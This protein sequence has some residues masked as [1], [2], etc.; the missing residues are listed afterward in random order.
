MIIPRQ[1]NLLADIKKKSFFLF[2]PRQT[3]KTH[4][5]RTTL[6]GYKY[7][8]LLA[9]DVYLR[10]SQSPKRLREEITKNDKIVIIDEIQKLPILLDEV[11]LLIEERGINFLLT[12]SSARKLRRKGV[13][14][15]GGR[16][17]TRHL[18]PFIFRELGDHFDL[19]K[20][21]DIGTIP[22]IYLSDSPHEDIEAYIGTYLTQEVAAEAL[23]RNIPA[24]SRF[25]LVAGTCNGQI[26]NFSN[27]ASDAQVPAS[28]IQEY[29]GIL[30]D[31]LIGDELPA[32][33]HSIKRKPLSTS[34]F[35]FF[36]IGLVRFLQNRQGLKP[37]SP[38]YGEAFE[39]YLY[40]ELR[41]YCD[42][43]R[44][45]TISY[46][47][48]K[49]GF[50]VDFILSDRTAIE[51]KAKTNIADKDLRGLKALQEEALLDSYIVVCLEDNPRVKDGISIL[52]WQVFLDYLWQDEYS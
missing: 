52:P 7:Y 10:L 5:I 31:T 45:D 37:G 21:L 48:S 27:I 29:F 4:L 32:W 47:R 15:L 12:G 36:D 38:E 6:S 20:A 22:S 23:V 42:Y 25:L 40:H 16:A 34:K 13:N 50:E 14:L 49:S 2:G 39:A 41:A 3:G 33:K 26:I 8:N 46:W 1:L 11:H 17:R 19:T 24:F 28:T 30:R 43:T 44:Q 51:V 9:T 35:F 18:H